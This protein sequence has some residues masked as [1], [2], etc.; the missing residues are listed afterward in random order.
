MNVRTNSNSFI[1]SYNEIDPET[2]QVTHTEMSILKDDPDCDSKV[3]ALITE[4]SA[5]Y[6]EITKRNTIRNYE[7]LIQSQET[8]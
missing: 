1:L 2:D 3:R 7:N 4:K 5:D 8:A 6:N